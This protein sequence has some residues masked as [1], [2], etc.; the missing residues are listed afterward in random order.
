MH[1]IGK[2]NFVRYAPPF[3]EVLKNNEKGKILLVFYIILWEIP[4]LIFSFQ[5]ESF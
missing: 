1:H 2:P 4:L 5:V 3:L